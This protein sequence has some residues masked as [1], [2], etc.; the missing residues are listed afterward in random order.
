MKEIKYDSNV[1]TQEMIALRARDIC[2][3]GAFE[4]AY[5]SVNQKINEL[6][7]LVTYLAIK[8]LKKEREQH[9]EGK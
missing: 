6:N 3:R 4:N 9:E 2:C 8:E 5:P 1:I 7:D